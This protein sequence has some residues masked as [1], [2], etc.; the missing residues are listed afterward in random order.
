MLTGAGVP[1]Q[2]VFL[3]LALGP[4]DRPVPVVALVPE[5]TAADPT[6]WSRPV[7]GS[8]ADEAGSTGL[9]RLFA[10]W[11]GGLGPHE[12]R[13]PTA[14]PVADV[15]LFVGG[16]ACPTVWTVIPGGSDTPREV[17]QRRPG[18]GLT[19]V[20][21]GVWSALPALA[22]WVDFE[23]RNTRGAVGFRL[24]HAIGW[25]IAGIVIARPGGLPPDGGI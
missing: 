1:P 20:Y 6:W 13:W 7:T 12:F 9:G 25:A 22:G 19:G 3:R 15:R 21:P 5:Y 4:A 14:E 11:A 18:A 2:P 17:D 8:V 23:C 10:A 16:P 24:P